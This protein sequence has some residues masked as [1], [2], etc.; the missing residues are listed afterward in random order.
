LRLVICSSDTLWP[1]SGCNDLVAIV[2]EKCAQ[3]A[4]CGVGVLSWR[5]VLPQ[6]LQQYLEVCRRTPK[7]Q[8]CVSRILAFVIAVPTLILV[9]IDRYHF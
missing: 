3:W 8:H 9:I 7:Q 6:I 4:I 1:I 2:M 5:T